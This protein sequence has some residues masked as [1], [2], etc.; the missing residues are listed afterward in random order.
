[1]KFTLPQI[2]STTLIALICVTGTAHA[3]L[4][5]NSLTQ[6]DLDG[7]TKEFSHNFM[8]TTVSGAS[9]LGSLWGFEVGVTG[10]QSD[11]DKIS[12]IIKRSSPN[13]DFESL[14]NVGLMGRVSIPF[15]L[16][17]EAGLLPKIKV[18]DA[19]LSQFA[20]A[21]RYNIIELPVAVG[22]RAHY[23]KTDFSFSQTSGAFTGN[24]DFD[25]DVYGVQ[26]LVSQNFVMIEPYA[27]IGFVEGKGDLNA[28][29]TG[30]IGSV[31]N[32]GSSEQSSLQVMGGL[33]LHLGFLNLGAEYSRAFETNRITGKLSFG[34]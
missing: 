5:F 20:G 28:V 8:F 33:N 10:G 32:S 4:N 2:F 21:V 6:S 14:Y 24:V 22:L 13:S 7:A 30:S 15:G 17:V 23:S 34:F 16:T 1:M 27:G 31:G 9:S 26:A 25:S 18:Q 11:A 19:E 3:Q 12:E 29:G